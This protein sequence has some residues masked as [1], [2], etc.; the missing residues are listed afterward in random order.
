MTTAPDALIEQIAKQHLGIET[1]ETRKSGGLDF[2]DCAVWSLKAALEAA[3]EAGRK[4][5]SPPRGRA[6]RTFRVHVKWASIE[7]EVYVEAASA[8]AAVATVR[9]SLT[10]TERRWASVFA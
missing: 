9:S 6:K 4:Y 1:L 8:E 3:F 2:H 10:G 7:R 5:A